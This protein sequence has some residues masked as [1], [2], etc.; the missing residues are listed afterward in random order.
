MPDPQNGPKKGPELYRRAKARIPGGTHLLSKR[1]EMF[2]PERWPAYFASAKGA[3]VVD[4]DGDRYLD[5]TI[6]GMGACVLGYADP[7]VDAA[8]H[9]VID[10]GVASSLNAPEEVELAELLCELHPWA[11]KVR[12]ARGGGEIVSIAI[13]IARAATRRDK[14]AFSG[15]HGWTD[16]YLSAN[17]GESDALDGH[18]LPGLEPAG[19]PRALRGT[20]LP[21]RYNQLDELQAIVDG[22]K[23]QIAAIVM[24][25]C[26]DEP[27]RPGYLEAVRQIATDIGA[28]LLFDEVTS[29]FRMNPGGIHLTMGVE[30]DLCTFA[31]AIGNGYAIAALVGRGAIM[32]AAQSTFISSTNWTERVGTTAAIATIKKFRREKVHEHLVRVGTA[33]VEGWQK[34]AA[35]AGLTV[36]TSKIPAI[37]HFRIEHPEERAM[38]TLFTQL[39]LERGILAS[40]N[41]R[42]S[43]AHTPAQVERYVAATREVFQHLADS[44]RRG[45]LDAQLKGP[46]QIRGFHRLTS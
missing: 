4:L 43:F 32:D 25:V 23:G 11:D 17:L 3:E 14:I 36:H 22:N 44:A 24:E 46:V 42:P 26:R 38:T 33:V 9:R 1:P 40:S 20:T 12:F 39:M 30:P 2:L 41:F 34:A 29:G 7:D 18:L 27:P 45:D 15:Y 8:V 10:Q 21:F 35:A 5:M 13:R 28:V 19:V 6:M 37:N 31:K 16:W